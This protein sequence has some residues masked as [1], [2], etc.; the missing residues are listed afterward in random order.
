MMYPNVE[1]VWFCTSSEYLTLLNDI[2]LVPAW[3]GK[4][5]EAILVVAQFVFCQKRGEYVL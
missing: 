1:I 2:F 3:Q 4:Q 5:N